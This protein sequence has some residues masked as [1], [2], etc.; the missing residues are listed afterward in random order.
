MMISQLTYSDRQEWIIRV[1]CLIIVTGVHLWLLLI[2]PLDFLLSGKLASK[3]ETID[4]HAASTL[5]VSFSDSFKQQ[6]DQSALLT[7]RKITKSHAKD[8]KA[9][10]KESVITKTPPLT[11]L[12]D[13][14]AMVNKNVSNRIIKPVVESDISFSQSKQKIVKIEESLIKEAVFSEIKKVNQDQIIQNQKEV[15]IYKPQ[16][17]AAPI[18]PKYPMIARRK[19]QQGTVWLDISLDQQ[20]QQKSL[21]IHKSSGIPVL[22]K[23]AIKAVKQWQFAQL[24]QS[25][26][27]QQVK[28]RIPIEFSLN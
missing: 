18:P 27:A 3:Y 28:I 16:L 7:K 25:Y 10:K 4:K 15:I 22:D 20:G 17:L 13:N 2:N 5:S 21:Y 8:N 19:K 6:K 24:K 1:G 9:I 23:A 14:K 11:S 26:H 12:G